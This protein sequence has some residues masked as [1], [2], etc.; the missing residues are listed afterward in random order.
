[1][2]FQPASD[3]IPPA[4][5]LTNSIHFLRG[6]AEPASSLTLLTFSKRVSRNEAISLD[7][8]ETAALNFFNKSARL[9]GVEAADHNAATTAFESLPYFLRTPATDSPFSF[10]AFTPEPTNFFALSH[11]DSKTRC[12]RMIFLNSISETF[13]SVRIGRGSPRT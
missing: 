10:T 11:H 5:L 2:P 6:A 9:S 4:A 7:F 12:S 1:M 8:E 3:S 13:P